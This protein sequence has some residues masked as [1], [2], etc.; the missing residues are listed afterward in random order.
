MSFHFLCPKLLILSDTSLGRCLHGSRAALCTLLSGVL[1][2]FLLLI[3]QTKH[4]ALFPFLSWSSNG[5]VLVEESGEIVTNVNGDTFHCYCYKMLVHCIEPQQQTDIKPPPGKECYGVFFLMLLLTLG[6][7]AVFHFNK[8][9]NR[10]PLLHQLCQVSK[11]DEIMQEEKPI[12][13]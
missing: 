1:S 3:Q 9:K 4:L 8:A 10:L 6:P 7:E 11:Q 2:R 12:I 13:S 5:G